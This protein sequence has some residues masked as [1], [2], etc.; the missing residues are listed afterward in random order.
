MLTKKEKKR[1]KEKKVREGERKRERKG[2]ETKFIVDF[3]GVIRSPS[4][5]APISMRARNF[6]GAGYQ[7]HGGKY[8]RPSA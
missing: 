3:M 5:R 4:D 2:K 7:M 8:R 6:M 1:K